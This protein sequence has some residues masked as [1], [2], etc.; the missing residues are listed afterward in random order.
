MDVCD[1]EHQSVSKPQR[2]RGGL[3]EKQ[4]RLQV[5][6][7]QVVPVLF[8]DFAHGRGIE[9]GCIVDEHVELAERLHCGVD[10]RTQ[11]LRLE[12]VAA[13]EC[14]GAAPQVV[15]LARERA[16]FGFGPVIVNH[17]VCARSLQRARDARAN[18]PRRAREQRDL[19]FER[20]PVSARA[21]RLPAGF[22][23]GA[24]RIRAGA[25]LGLLRAAS[26]RA[27]AAGISC[28]LAR[29]FSFGRHG[30]GL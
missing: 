18:A 8:R 10:E 25:R 27:G 30:C 6:A 1:V 14:R 9:S 20:E 21:T 5:G 7:E 13:N 24:K 12:Q 2:R 4:R 15:E 23:D 17:H 19:A 16:G 3:C 29:S 11:F 22:G 26:A 28:A